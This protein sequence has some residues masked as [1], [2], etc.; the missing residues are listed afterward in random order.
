MSYNPRDEVSG[1]IANELVE[2]LGGMIITEEE[3]EGK[4]FKCYEYPFDAYDKGCDE[5]ISFRT[6]EDFDKVMNYIEDDNQEKFR[7][8]PRRLIL[9]DRKTCEMRFNLD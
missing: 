6:P 9:A 5:I 3:H 8:N 2:I 1:G 7:V 4:M